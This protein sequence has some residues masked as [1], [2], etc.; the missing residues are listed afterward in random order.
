MNHA[1]LDEKTSVL[2]I[3]TKVR[4]RALFAVVRY[5]EAVDHEFRNLAEDE[6]A[7][8][9]SDLWVAA[10]LDAADAVK[11]IEDMLYEEAESDPT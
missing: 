4:A 6:Q 8:E 1:E 2:L 11:E 7:V 3:T 9:G 5:L 10:V